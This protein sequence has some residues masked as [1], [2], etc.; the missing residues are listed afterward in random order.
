MIV[1]SSKQDSS[2]KFPIIYLPSSF[3]MSFYSRNSRCFTLKTFRKKLFIE[4]A[5]VLIAKIPEINY[6]LDICILKLYLIMLFGT[7]LNKLL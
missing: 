3:L 4:H 2:Y 1:T 5:F 7:K 6:I